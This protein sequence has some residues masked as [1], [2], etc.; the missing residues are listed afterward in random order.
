MSFQSIQAGNRLD[1]K[2][3]Y[4]NIGDM[5][6]TSRVLNILDAKN[7]TVAITMP[8]RIDKILNMLPNKEY[9]VTAYID[10]AIMVFKGFFEGYARR[11]EDHFVA[12]RLSTAG[13]KI[14]RRE[15]FRQSEKP[16]G[17]MKGFTKRLT[18]IFR[19]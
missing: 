6:Y 17:G 15:F 13:Y 12:L 3:Q 16:R 18:K 14:R 19:N 9:K 10:R 1:I 7:Q 8:V 2:V 5:V 11:G 4:R